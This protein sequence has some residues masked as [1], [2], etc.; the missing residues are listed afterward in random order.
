MKVSELV[1]LDSDSFW[2][3]WSGATKRND[4]KNSG[5]FLLK[6]KVV[7]KEDTITLRLFKFIDL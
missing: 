4:K 1:N 7:R 6:S 3:W 5:L 2:K